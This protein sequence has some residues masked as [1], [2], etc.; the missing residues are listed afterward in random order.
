MAID[1]T[2][3]IAPGLNLLG[4]AYGANQQADI[5]TQQAQMSQ[6]RPVGVT[7]RFG[8]S[9]F[10]YDPTTGQLTGA[11]Y[12]VAPDVAAM[13]EGLLGLAGGQLSQAQQAQAFQPQFTQAGQGLF[14]LGQGYIAQSPQ[15]AAQDWMAKQQQLLAPGR[16]QQLAQLT[17][18]EFQRGTLGLATGATQAGYTPTAPSQGISSGS[19]MGQQLPPYAM[20]QA[21]A[22]P[23][24]TEEDW[25]RFSALAYFAPGT[26]MEAEK[27]K[28]MSGG[29]GAP[30]LTATNMPYTP[31]MQAPTQQ[32]QSAGLM[33]TN[34]RFAELAN[35]RALADA[36]MAANAQ[37]FG[38]Q[39]VQF[40]QGLL[41]GGMDVMR[42]GYG[43]QTAALQPFTAYQT[44]AQ[45]IEDA[46]LKALTQGVSLGSSSA[47]AGAQAA[48]QYMQGQAAQQAALQ[49][50][51]SGLSDPIAQLIKGLL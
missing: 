42:G 26:D 1:W 43:V 9:G 24:K 15:Q 30:S 49:G 22:R 35:A 14:N 38:Q 28:F 2:S 21:Q 34:P 18:Q 47:A 3:L 19:S 32:P 4:S 51:I 13:R 31:G 46:A 10:T 20:Q 40:G 33:A 48:Q 39:Q 23:P 41:T 16:E 12:Q 50:A 27:A 8:K 17:N 44:Q 25:N 7:T 45:N 37:K 11:G 6:F 36:T 5:A 29:A